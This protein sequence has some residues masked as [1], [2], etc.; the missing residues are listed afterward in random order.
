MKSPFPRMPLMLRALALLAPS[1]LV[2]PSA[3]AGASSADS[4][5]APDEDVVFTCAVGAK[6]VSV[7]ASADLSPAAGVAQYRFGVPRKTPE[8]TL[9][10]GKAHPARVAHGQSESF[11]GGGGAWLRFR[12]GAYAYV[13][14]TG[15]GKW[16][17]KGTT[18]E[19]AGVIV[20]KDGARVASLQCKGKAQ[21][22]L[23]PEWFEKAGIQPAGE[24][25]EF[26]E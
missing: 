14:Y 25:F 22:E 19:K 7:C 15:I 3:H 12:Q 2:S 21:S 10:S 13:V 20:E 6:S 26:P 18:R 5:C 9:P 17:P 24:T 1:L 16:G 4:L 11:S 23:G 8:L